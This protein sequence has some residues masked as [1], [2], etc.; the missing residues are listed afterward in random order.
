[1]LTPS[2]RKK[3]RCSSSHVPFD[4]LSPHSK[5][6]RFESMKEI[7]HSLKT[8]AEYFSNK[9]SQLLATDKQNSEIGQLVSAIS[10]STHGNDSL[11]EIFAEADKMQHG[12]GK[13][14]KDVWEEDV[15]DWKLFVENQENNGNC[16]TCILSI[17][18]DKNNVCFINLSFRKKIKQVV[19]SYYWIRLVTF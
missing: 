2:Q 1:M 13:T 18:I 19:S 16:S 11:H 17:I 7:I 5:K 12:L 15:N 9:I 10:T 3:R 4:V 6:A 8:R 14:V